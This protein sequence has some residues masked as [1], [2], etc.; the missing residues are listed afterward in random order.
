MLT[1][2]GVPVSTAVFGIVRLP[3]PTVPLSPV[4][5]KATVVM[6]ADGLFAIVTLLI[7]WLVMFPLIAIL[8]VAPLTVVALNVVNCCVVDVGVGEGVWLGRGEVVEVG[9][10]ANTAERVVAP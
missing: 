2:G 5:V 7:C 3:S 10:G 9:S 4:T 8:T 6:G 1:V